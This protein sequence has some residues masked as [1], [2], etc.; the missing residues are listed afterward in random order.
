MARNRSERIE[1][2]SLAESLL[3]GIT[4]EERVEETL[5]Y[6]E[7]QGEIAGYHRS[8]DRL[9]WLG[10]DFTVYLWDEMEI[11][12]LPLQVKSSFNNVRRHVRKHPGVP[13]V[14]VREEDDLRDL[15]GK[16][17]LVLNLWHPLVDE[18]SEQLFKSLT[19]QL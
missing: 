16:V 11:H 10:I 5:R 17:A 18:L 3:T 4:S 9:D 15:V 14:V 12:A 13:C 8:D 2:L 1:D 7:N 6:L 19:Y